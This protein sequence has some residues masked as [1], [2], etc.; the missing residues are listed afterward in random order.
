MHTRCT[1]FL[2]QSRSFRLWLE[3][4]SKNSYQNHLAP[5]ESESSMVSAPATSPDDWLTAYTAALDGKAAGTV[6]ASLRAL[7]QFLTWLAQRPGN[8]DGFVAEQVTRT[9]VESYLAHLEQRGSSR[10]HRVRVKAVLSSFATWLMEE[11]HGLLRNPT[12]GVT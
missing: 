1:S 6:N 11:Q 3:V 9:A 2:Y 10:S 4:G 12:R 8:A 5:G 7:R